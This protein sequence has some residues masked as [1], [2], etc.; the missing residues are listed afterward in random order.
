MNV[1][2]ND[3]NQHSILRKQYQI[4]SK[5]GGMAYNYWMTEIFVRLFTF[6]FFKCILNS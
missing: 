6:K 4:C 5:V 3:I 1:N 2:Y